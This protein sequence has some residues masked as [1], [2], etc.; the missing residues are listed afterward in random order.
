MAPSQLLH[1]DMD[2]R[3]KSK[4]RARVVAIENKITTG[5][6]DL[7]RGRQRRHRRWRGHEYRV[8]GNVVVESEKAGRSGDN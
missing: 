8:C 6:E 2:A 3:I 5:K 1:D 7:T 4:H